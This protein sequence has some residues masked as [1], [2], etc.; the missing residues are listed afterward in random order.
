M[1]LRLFHLPHRLGS[2]RESS[3]TAAATPYRSL[4]LQAQRLTPIVHR[5]SSSARCHGRVPCRTDHTLKMMMKCQLRMSV[6]NLQTSDGETSDCVSSIRGGAMAADGETSDSRSSIRRGAMG[7]KDEETSSCNAGI[8]EQRPVVVVSENT[9][10]RTATI[11]AGSLLLF[12]SLGL[13]KVTPAFAR[14]VA[15]PPSTTTTTTTASLLQEE[16]EAQNQGKSSPLSNLTETETS[17][18]DVGVSQQN[19]TPDKEK[20]PE[21]QTDPAELVLLKFL[22]RHPEDLKALEGLMYVRLRKGDVKAA[23]KILEK[24]LELRPAHLPWQL[25]RAQ[26]L[27]FVGDLDE[28]R[29]AFQAILEKN[30]LSAR[31]LQGLA[32]VMS[33]TGEEKESLEM[34]KKAVDAALKAERPKE[35]INVRMLLAQMHT[36]QGNLKEALDEYQ[37]VVKVDPTDFRPY[38]CQGL[39][40][41]ILGK[42][43]EAEKQFSKYRQLCPNTFPNRGYL[44]DLLLNAKTMARKIESRKGKKPAP[45]KRPMKPMRQPTAVGVGPPPDSE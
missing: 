9:I 35:A 29:Q 4:L 11:L 13:S 15:S 31:A 44:D 24:L 8:K 3:P 21:F 32:I 45:G 10:S 41:S 40:Y 5:S 6:S 37:D 33:K 28:A 26:S 38:L 30:P 18:S 17:S 42:T 19:T 34:L 20:V 14:R 39:V 23:L 43:E 2:S 27:D 1:A 36:M 16:E 22:E 25:I 12:L 7:A